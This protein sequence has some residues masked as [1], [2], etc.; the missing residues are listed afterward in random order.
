LLV[1]KLL[2]TS[3]LF[4]KFALKAQNLL[5]LK[6]SQVTAGQLSLFFVAKAFLLL[7]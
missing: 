4:Q 3:W 7:F 1:I 2:V 5:R 6:I